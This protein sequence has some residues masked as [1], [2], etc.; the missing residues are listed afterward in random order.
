[1]IH[2]LDAHRALFRRILAELWSVKNN[3]TIEILGRHNFAGAVGKTN[4]F[5]GFVEAQPLMPEGG[6]HITLLGVT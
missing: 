6:A 2:L 5:H 3:L 4:P 1:M